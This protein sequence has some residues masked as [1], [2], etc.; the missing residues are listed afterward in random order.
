MQLYCLRYIKSHS[1]SGGVFL[2]LYLAISLEK[3][4]PTHAVNPVITPK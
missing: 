1:E 2:D 4:I 3:T